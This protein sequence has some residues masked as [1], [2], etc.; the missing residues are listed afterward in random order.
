MI[1]PLESYTVERTKKGLIATVTMTPPQAND[2]NEKKR[3]DKDRNVLLH[4]ML[5]HMTDRGEKKY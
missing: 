1:P 5:S 2:K 4:Q 3:T